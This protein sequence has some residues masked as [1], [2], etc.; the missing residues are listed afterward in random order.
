M[1]IF[2]NYSSSIKDPY[3]IQIGDN[4]FVLSFH[5]MKLLPALHMLKKAQAERKI[6]E[7]SLIVE[8]SSGSFAYGIALACTELKLPFAIVTDHKIDPLIKEQVMG[9]KGILYIVRKKAENGGIQQARLNKLH[10]VLAAN[11]GSFWPCQYDNPD[12]QEAYHSAGERLIETLGKNLILVGSVGSGGS[13]C[14][15]ITAMRRHNN[16]IPLIGVDTFN[17]V[18]FGMEDGP[19]MLRGLGNSIIPK[20]LHHWYFDEV[21]WVSAH[22]AFNATRN[23]HSSHGLFCGPTT[24][25]AYAVG[26]W[27]SKLNPLQK[28][29]LI[30]PDL[31]HRYLSS[32]YNAKWMKKQGFFHPLNQT[33]PAK[34]LH[35]KEAQGDWACFSWGRK[36]LDTVL[37]R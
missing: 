12:N 1:N 24:G 13:T 6:Q 28:T 7:N 15:L 10:E 9:Q 3:L 19:R 21:H 2:P 14:G 27:I 16:D 20:N 26:Q 32:V 5:V 11:T 30:S 8:T 22:L 37:V 34:V 17:S 4:L 36:T 33:S 23:L 25:A 35:P 31:G 18:L 29:I